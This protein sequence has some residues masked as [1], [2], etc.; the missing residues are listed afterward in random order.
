MKDMNV[1]KK[2]LAECIGTMAIVLFGCGVAVAT[3][4]SDNG[5]IL[6]TALAFGLVILT[7]SFTLG[8]VSGCHLNPAVSFA[9]WMDKRITFGQFIGYLISQVIGA[10]IG[11]FEVA[12]FFGSFDDLGANVAQPVLTSAYGDMGALWVALAVETILTFAFVFAVLGVTKKTENKTATGVVIGLALTMVHLLGIRLTGTSVNPARS[13]GPALIQMISG[14]F[15]PISQI[16]IFIVGPMLGAALAVVLFRL[17]W[18]KC[19]CG[20]NGSDD[21]ECGSNCDCDGMTDCECG[22]ECDCHGS[23]DCECGSEWDCE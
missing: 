23:S 21:C 20:C 22:E 3:G 13:L 6:A 17:I 11:S 9:M 2:Y 5:G 1:M 12:L 14:D 15:T 8:H 4:V 18:G 7:M 16:W 10:V 19:N